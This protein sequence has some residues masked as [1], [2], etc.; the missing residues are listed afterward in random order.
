MIFSYLVIAIVF[1]K[2]EIGRTFFRSINS[3]DYARPK[4]NAIKNLKI[5]SENVIYCKHNHLK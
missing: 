5:A 3:I 1:E 2:D 4:T